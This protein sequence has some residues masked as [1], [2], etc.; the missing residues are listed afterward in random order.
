MLLLQIL[1]RALTWMVFA[2][3]ALARRM[4]QELLWTMMRTMTRYVTSM[5]SSVVKTHW[6]AITCLQQPMQA[7]ASMPQDVITVQARRTGQVK[8]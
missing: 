6:P 2:N 5:R 1:A 4:E 3:H 8:S 7:R